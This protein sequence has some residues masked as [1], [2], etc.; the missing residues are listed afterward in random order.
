LVRAIAGLWPWGQG[1]IAIPR[2]A[3]L[4]LMPQRPYIPL[5]SLRR[6]ATYPL[7]A[8]EIPDDKLRELMELVGIGY[9]TA[10]LDVEASWDHV[11]S[12]GEKQRIGFVRLLLHQP[13][14]V[15][16]DEATSAL[17]PASQEHL[18]HIVAERLAN[19]ALV[20]VAHRP[21]LEAFHQR[22]LVFEHLPGGSRV[23]SEDIL[24][25]SPTLLTWLL[26]RIEQL[27][28]A[29]TGGT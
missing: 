18:M 4:F 22:K 3:K 21:E 19:V 28:G 10:R 6:A 26:S 14:I 24:K 29:K 11:L 2:H 15:V 25:K 17:D 8:N 1:E 5:G 20:S 9:L 13:D 27:R 7:P 23:I 16:M 12:G